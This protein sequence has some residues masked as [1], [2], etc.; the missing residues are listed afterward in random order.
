VFG[1]KATSSSSVQTLKKIVRR[2]PETTT[3][4]YDF[5]A[6][7]S[8]L[9]KKKITEAL[10]YDS[11][12]CGRHPLRNCNKIRWMLVNLRRLKR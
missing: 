12:S 8:K 1:R 9:K 3:L 4:Y 5:N 10:G 6:E 2:R 7:V 11:C